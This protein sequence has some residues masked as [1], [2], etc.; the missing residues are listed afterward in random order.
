MLSERLAKKKY[1][2]AK[3]LQRPVDVDPNYLYE[4][5]NRRLSAT[6]FK[7]SRR[8]NLAV[9]L[10]LIYNQSIATVADLNS[11]LQAESDP[12]AALDAV[13][14]LNEHLDDLADH[15]RTSGRARQRLQ[16]HLAE[17]TLEGEDGS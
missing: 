17:L 1:R 5:L 13:A 6:G 10:E 15:M 4:R 3:E 11:L 12:D 14:S 2:R 9:D 7:G 16:L 8:Y